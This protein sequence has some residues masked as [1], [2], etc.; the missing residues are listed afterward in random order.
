MSGIFNLNISSY[1]INELKNILNL[2]DPYTLEDI[3]NNENTLR[4]KL[5]MDHN[6]SED[7]K[8]DIIKFD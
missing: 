3:V 8:K 2:Q 4:E 6:I 1:D 5:L 7:K